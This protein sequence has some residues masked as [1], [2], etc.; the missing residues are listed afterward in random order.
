MVV[1]YIILGFLVP[2]VMVFAYSFW[3]NRRRRTP[4][5][6]ETD[7]KETDTKETDSDTE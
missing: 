7:T 6:K 1:L 2:V 4:D 5:T 3:L